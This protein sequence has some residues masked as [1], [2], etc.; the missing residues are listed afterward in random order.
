MD[1]SPSAGLNHREDG[2]MASA[3]QGTGFSLKVVSNKQHIKDRKQSASV[4]DVVP[5]S[6]MM[7]GA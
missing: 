2:Y 7:G 4:S 5:V 1:V 6:I 3:T